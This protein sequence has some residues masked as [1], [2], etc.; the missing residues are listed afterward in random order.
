MTLTDSSGN[1]L[2]EA[3]MAKSYSSVVISTPEMQVGQTYTLTCGDTSVEAELTDTITALGSGG[4]FGSPG[5][6]GGGPGG[7]P[8]W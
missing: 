5:G 3:E 7:P 4:G 8:G 2:L 1:V 6:P